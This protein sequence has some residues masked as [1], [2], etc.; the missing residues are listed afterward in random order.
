MHVLTPTPSE[1]EIADLK[2]AGVYVAGF[3]DSRIR[4]REDLFD[5]L[6]DGMPP[7]S[8]IRISFDH[9]LSTHPT[10]SPRVVLTC[11]LRIV[12][13]K[14]TVTIASDAVDD[15]VET[16]LHSDLSQ[17]IKS[18]LA[19]EG[20]DNP[21]IVKAYK[22][23]TQEL[24]TKLNSL[25]EQAEGDDKAYISFASLNRVQLPPHLD[26]FLYAVASAEGMTKLSVAS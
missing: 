2:A 1:E 6:I 20:I 15:F 24:L 11:L 4:S 5:I 26:A 14:A 19:T 18:A 10:H 3:L 9:P 7:H 25:K 16:K 12:V 23:K 22:I 17:F 21:K 8:T 13:P